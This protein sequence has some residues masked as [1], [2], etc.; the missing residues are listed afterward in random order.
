[1]CQERVARAYRDQT[2]WTRMSIMNTARM[3]QFSSDRTVRQYAEE[4]WGLTPVR[5]I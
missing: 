1:M 4:I 5:S 3:G 2:A